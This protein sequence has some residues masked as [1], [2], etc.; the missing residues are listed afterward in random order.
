MLEPAPLVPPAF[1]TPM[2]M[3]ISTHPMISIVTL[4]LRN[5]VKC[6]SLGSTG[7]DAGSTA[8]SATRLTDPFVNVTV[9][10][11]ILDPSHV[12]VFPD[13]AYEANS[14]L[15]DISKSNFLAATA[16]K[17]RNFILLYY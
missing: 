3:N 1:E 16:A 12:V 13:A 17:I 8:Y 15:M 6:V 11:H 5:G 10:V 14:S 9:P 7:A 2:R 4:P